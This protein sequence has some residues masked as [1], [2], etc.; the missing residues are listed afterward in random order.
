ME[1]NLESVSYGRNRAGVRQLVVGSASACSIADCKCNPEA[2]QNPRSYFVCSRYRYRNL[3]KEH[4]ALF[5]R[6]FEHEFDACHKY[7]E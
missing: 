6:R 7:L 3:L 5:D 4:A 2:A 1:I